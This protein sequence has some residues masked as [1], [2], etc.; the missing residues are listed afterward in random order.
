MKIIIE[1]I[2]HSQQRYPTCGDWMT[3]KDGVNHIFVSE[4]GNEDYNFLI[5]I[6]ELIEQK[7]CNKKGVKE[8]DVTAFDIK[9]EEMRKAF[10]EMV[11]TREAGDVETAPYFSEHRYAT[12]V[13]MN[14]STQLGVDYPVYNE[15][16]N[17]LQ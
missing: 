6:H 4:T 11:G 17:T 5:A 9:F 7:L 3:D 14:M 10:P 1:T 15:A 8:E 2:P 16:I 13:E 12:A